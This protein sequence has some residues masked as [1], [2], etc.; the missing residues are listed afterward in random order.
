MRTKTSCKSGKVTANH[1]E[2]LVRDCGK[3]LKIQTALRAGK[4]AA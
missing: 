2:K 1:N 4:K 3:S